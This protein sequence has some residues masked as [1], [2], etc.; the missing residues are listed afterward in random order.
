MNQKDDLILMVPKIE[1]INEQTFA[2][3]NGGATLSA[4]P[5]SMEQ[6]QGLIDKFPS[7]EINTIELNVKGAAETNGLTKLVIGMSGEAGIKLILNKK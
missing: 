7:Y 2:P 6:I 1:E 3:S 5:I 4:L